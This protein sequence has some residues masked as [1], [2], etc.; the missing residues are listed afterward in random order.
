MRSDLCETMSAIV[1]FNI[2]IMNCTFILI[3]TALKFKKGYNRE[4][5]KKLRKDMKKAEN[6]K[7]SVTE[8]DEESK[9][10]ES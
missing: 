2:V 7:R 8:A 3:S 5:M 4:L 10:A 9:L 6:D 1:T